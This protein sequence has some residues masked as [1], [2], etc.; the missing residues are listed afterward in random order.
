MASRTRTGWM[1]RQAGDRL[2]TVAEVAVGDVPVVVR[3][4]QVPLATRVLRAGEARRP[5]VPLLLL[6]SFFVLRPDDGEELALPGG[7]TGNPTGTT[8]LPGA[9]P[10]VRPSPTPRETLPPVALAGSRDPFSIPT[11]LELT[12]GSVGPPDRGGGHEHDDGPRVDDHVLASA[13]HDDVHAPAPRPPRRPCR[14]GPVAA[15]ATSAR[16]TRS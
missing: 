1:G 13:A 15:T 16:P 9:S 2:L 12:G 11:G 14:R 8:G 10:S 6:V 4:A 5:R 3:T 7:S